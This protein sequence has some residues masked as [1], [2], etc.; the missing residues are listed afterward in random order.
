MIKRVAIYFSLPIWYLNTFL[1]ILFSSL[2]EGCENTKACYGYPDGCISQGKCE[3][4]LSYEPQ[5][6]NY[7]FKM[8]V[9]L[10]TV[11]NLLSNIIFPSFLQGR[12][13]GYIAMGLSKD[14]KMGDDL[15]TN[16]YRSANG[17]IDISTGNNRVNNE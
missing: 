2:F 17:R 1:K 12:T 3:V 15:T 16:C 8:K 6:L 7:L 11:Q 14:A 13:S 5:Q 9:N 10:V 4:V